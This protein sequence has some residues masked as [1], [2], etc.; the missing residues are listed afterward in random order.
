MSRQCASTQSISANSRQ[1]EA[2]GEPSVQQS[3]HRKSAPGIVVTVRVDEASIDRAPA[4]V[5]EETG[6]PTVEGDGLQ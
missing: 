5:A 1:R 2:C 6:H 4:A 3:A